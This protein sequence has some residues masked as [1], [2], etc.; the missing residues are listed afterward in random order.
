M[1][2]PS[3]IRPAATC[4]ASVWVFSMAAWAWNITGLLWL[5]SM[6]PGGSAEKL[7]VASVKESLLSGDGILV[8]NIQSLDQEAIHKKRKSAGA[9]M[10]S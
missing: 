9:A 7:F 1:C 10:L 8:P 3:A 4:S 2:M 5:P 6:A